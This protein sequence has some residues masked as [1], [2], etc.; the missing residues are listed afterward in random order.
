M[1]PVYT[2][3][4]SVPVIQISCVNT[5]HNRKPQSHTVHSAWS[6]HMHHASHVDYGFIRTIHILCMA[7]TQDHELVAGPLKPLP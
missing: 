3:T 5:A 2:C 1:A 7:F 4:A 6:S